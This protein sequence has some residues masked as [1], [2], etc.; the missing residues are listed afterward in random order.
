MQLSSI[1][2]YPNRINLYTNLDSW[3]SERNRS[4]YNRNLKIYRGVDNRLE[5]R[6]KNSDQKPQ[7]VTGQFFVFTLMS[8][9][10]DKV[11]VRKDCQAESAEEG[12]IFVVL[13]KAEL[14]GLDAGYYEHSIAVESRT[15]LND[16]EYTVTL[17]SPTYVDSQY[18]VMGVSEILDDLQGEPTPPTVIREFKRYVEPWH[19][20]EYYDSGI[21]YTGSQLVEANSLHTLQ[22]FFS[23]YTGK[24]SVQGSIDE[25][26][27]PQTWSDIKTI[28]Y[29]G[30]GA[31]YLN[32]VGKFNFLRVRHRPYTADLVGSFQI[33]LTIT[34]EYQVTVLEAGLNYQVGNTILIKGNR[35]GGEQ[36]SN[37][38]TITVDGV[39][40]NGGITSI[41]W[42]G[43]SYNGVTRYIIS[44]E[45]IQTSGTLD[46][47]I[48][49]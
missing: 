25:G 9:D 34:G 14:E 44:N 37:D 26:G 20:E 49:R 29:I 1:Y 45:T 40:V 13:S 41:S 17:S 18:G 16:D 43:R 27:N 8:R 4:V 38:L 39:D 47:I 10:T 2:L 35:L 6:V 5:F 7:D 11:A 15:M 36:G 3:L 28:E 21:M 30:A 24:V 46:K 32:V 31:E 48:Y 19:D 42:Q 12:K 33:D 23:N 22:F